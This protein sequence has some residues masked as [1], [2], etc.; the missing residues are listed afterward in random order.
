MGNYCV[1]SAG[2]NKSA[3]MS[4]SNMEPIQVG[5]YSRVYGL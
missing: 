1:R 5:R 4:V 3:V 2:E